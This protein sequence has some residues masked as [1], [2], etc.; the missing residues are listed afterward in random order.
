MNDQAETLSGKRY[1]M[2]CLVCDMLYDADRIDSTTC[3][4]A[5]R[6]KL[7][8]KPEIKQKAK[9]ITEDK[10]G[11]GEILNSSA[12][13]DLCPDVSSKVMAGEMTMKEANRQ[14][15]I[16]FNQLILSR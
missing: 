2:K 16:K 11:I 7:H 1:V 15:V 4:P 9:A 6:T 8:R 10:F 14:A 12:I 3:S 5:C 13:Q